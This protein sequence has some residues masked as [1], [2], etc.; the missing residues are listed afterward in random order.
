MARQQTQIRLD[1]V[2]AFLNRHFDQ[3][4]ARQATVLPERKRYL[5]ARAAGIVP[6]QLAQRYMNLIHH[7]MG[8]YTDEL[9]MP[10]Y[11]DGDTIVRVTENLD[12]IDKKASQN[13]I[14]KSKRRTAQEIKDNTENAEDTSNVPRSSGDYELPQ[15]RGYDTRPPRRR[16]KHTRR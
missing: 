3:R 11:R 10:W 5:K 15:Q 6:L 8:T 1:S 7:G 14:P 9:G 12:W 2:P 13:D 4:Q 16:K